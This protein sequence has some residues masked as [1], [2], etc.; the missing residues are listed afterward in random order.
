MYL[1]NWIYIT[2]EMESLINK[3]VTTHL[4]DLLL[5]ALIDAQVLR[6]AS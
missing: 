6:K 2:L 5:R 4:L 3:N 1:R